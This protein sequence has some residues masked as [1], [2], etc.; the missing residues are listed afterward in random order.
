MQCV[1]VIYQQVHHVWFVVSQRFNGVKDVDTALLPQHLTD[2]TDAAENPTA[3]PS[4]PGGG[5]GEERRK[6]GEELEIFDSVLV[7]FSPPGGDVSPLMESISSVLPVLPVFVPVLPVFVLAVSVVLSVVAVLSSVLCFGVFL[8]AVDHG[9]SLPAVILLL[10]FVHLV[11]QFEEGA[12]GDGCVPVHRPAQELELLHH[13]V[14][15]LRLGGRSEDRGV[16]TSL[17]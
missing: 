16:K 8:Q 2:Y 9:A 10:P 14:P 5:Q 6:Q 13:A 4:I 11:N 3:T 17:L 1:V 7:H 15:V 12:L